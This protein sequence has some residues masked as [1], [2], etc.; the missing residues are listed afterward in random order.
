[1]DYTIFD[2]N[3]KV[4]SNSN[5]PGSMIYNKST[6]IH[7]IEIID[8]A[9]MDDTVFDKSVKVKSKSNLS[10]FVK[11]KSPKVHLVEEI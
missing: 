10:S 2:K 5:S 6:N 9:D 1:M 4:K 7:S 11:N 3:V 8:F